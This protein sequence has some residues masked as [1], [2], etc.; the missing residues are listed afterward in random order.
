MAC[1]VQCRIRESLRNSCSILSCYPLL[2]QYCHRFVI[3]Q[4]D[5]SCLNTYT[6]ARYAMNE[7]STGLHGHKA[8]L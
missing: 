8:V 2:L 5:G 6:V 1:R 7:H 3:P 4:K